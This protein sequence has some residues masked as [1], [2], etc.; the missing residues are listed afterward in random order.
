LLS[1]R[2]ATQPSAEI[3]ARPLAANGKDA[4]TNR[5]NRKRSE[6]YALGKRPSPEM[7]IEAR[8]VA[9]PAADAIG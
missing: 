8:S 5:D 4:E 6:Q 2:H 7:R 3:S 9:A 1:E